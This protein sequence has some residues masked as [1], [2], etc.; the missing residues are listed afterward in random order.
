MATL[1][2]GKSGKAVERLQAALGVAIDGKFGDATVAAL[3]AWQTAQGL[4]A[5]GVAGPDV[6]LALGLGDMIILQ[7]GDSGELV[8]RLQTAIGVAASGDYDD[9]TET[10][11]DKWQQKAGMD[12]TGIAK[13]DTLARLGVLGGAAATAPAK[14]A[15]KQ[16]TSAPQPVPTATAAAPA[17]PISTWAYQLADIDPKD[18]IALDV[19][20]VVIDYS[21]DGEDATAFKH[22]EVAAMKRRP[23]GGR[24]KKVVSYMSIGEAEN[25]RYY[26]QDAWNDAKTKPAFLD[27]ENPDW[28]GNFKVRYWDPAWQAVIMGNAGAYLDRIIAAG[29]DGVYLDIIDAFEYWK[30]VKGERAS[31][32]R[33]MIAFVTAIARYARRK[34]PD[35]MVIPQNGEALL[36]DAGY[37]AVISAQ[38]KEDIF[39]GADGDGHANKKGAVAECLDCLAHARNAGLPILAVE[40]LNDGRKI[41]DAGSRL[42]DAGCT[43]YFGPRDLDGISKDQFSP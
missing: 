18:I 3:K 2:K 40:Y 11:I 14:A 21:R 43:P 38:A 37:R 36:E 15:P 28:E 12:Y 42:K 8:K 5:N 33:E 24:S 22:A 10:A 25:Y 35:F 6:Q 26:W 39:Y 17:G 31:A 7:N 9:D 27:D 1:K 20:L 16:S 4:A 30:D 19:D 23:G 29:F 41:A 32:D 34:R 13:Q